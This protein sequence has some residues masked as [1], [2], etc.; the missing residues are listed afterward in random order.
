MKFKVWDSVDK[1]FVD[2]SCFMISSEGD[3]YKHNNQTFKFE[4]VV[5]KHFIPV[6]STGQTDK[7][8]V[9][10][11]EVDIVKSTGK[12]GTL[13]THFGERDEKGDII[14]TINENFLFAPMEELGSNHVVKWDVDYAGWV[15]FCNYDS[16]CGE[17]NPSEYFEIIG[18]KFKNPELLEVK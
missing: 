5:K 2:S 11:Y 12:I 17:Y 9:E 16:D 1:K 18:N 6:L 3:L 10:I 7:N 15:P 14:F 8:G 13:R 4:S